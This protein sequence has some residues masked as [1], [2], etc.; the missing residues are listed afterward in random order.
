[1]QEND[2]YITNH[3]DAIKQKANFLETKGFSVVEVSEFIINYANQDNCFIVIYYGRYDDEPEI[4]VRFEN[5]G[6]IPEQY[7][8]GWFRNMKKFEAGE[9]ATVKRT[10]AKVDKLTAIF[11][12]LEYLQDNFD[13]ITDIDFCR[14]TRKKINEN[15]ERGLWKVGE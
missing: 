7:S 10:G 13:D 8:L 14:R 2:I 15:F 6:L 1:M 3:I 11:S 9:K 4:S 5:K 12:L